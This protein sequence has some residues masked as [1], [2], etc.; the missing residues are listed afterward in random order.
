MTYSYL[1]SGIGMVVKKRVRT[2]AVQATGKNLQF[3]L[4]ASPRS[5]YQGGYN[6]RDFGCKQARTGFRGVRAKV[7]LPR[8]R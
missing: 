8:H 4:A 3:Y 1:E 2:G 6:D 7:S 5:L